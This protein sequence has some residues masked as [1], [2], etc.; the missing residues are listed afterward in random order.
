MKLPALALHR[1][2]FNRREAIGAARS[3]RLRHA[4]PSERKRQFVVLVLAFITLL[5]HRFDRARW[6]HL[7]TSSA[8]RATCGPR[9]SLAWL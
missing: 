5:L 9:S 4:A 3:R 8:S 7:E 1:G 6:P 2:N